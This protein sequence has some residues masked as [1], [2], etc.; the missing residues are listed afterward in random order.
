MQILTATEAIS[1]AFA[2]TKL[3]L[4]SPFRAG[5]TWKLSAT[6][7]LSFAGTVF[8]PF[9]LIYAAAGLLI[10]ALPHVFRVLIV[11][12]S[13][14]LTAI[15]ILA[16]WLCGRLKFAFFD[17]V[18]HRGE[19]V[20]P[21]WRKYG[22]QSRQWTL[23][24]ML[25]GSVFTMVLALPAYAV[26]RTFISALPA[27]QA[28]MSAMDKSSGFPPEMANYMAAFYGAYFLIMLIVAAYFIVISTISSFV[29]PTMALEN[30]SVGD[31][32]RRFNTFARREPKQLAAFV[33][34]RIGLAIVGYMGT[35]LAYEIVLF[36][37]MAVAALVCGIIGLLLHL[38]GV[39]S[40]V[41]LVLGGIVLFFFVF[42]VNGY[43][44][45][46]ALGPFFAFF[47]AHTL[48][49]LGGRY[50]LLGELL[51][52]STPAPVLASPQSPPFAQPYYPPPT[53]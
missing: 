29:V 5:R 1:P 42:V 16:F 18:L 17:I 46:L 53:H 2:R 41:L 39:P 22:E 19:F 32:F 49:F 26:F 34:V 51:E 24:K 21:A 28:Q 8:L 33:G 48:Y 7:Y 15:Y 4:Y 36:I 43:L 37:L 40:T 6:A 47:E 52:R 25:L 23:T 13:I 30:A 11:A 50:P 35:T 38:A 45:L 31:A 44:L 12:G 9:T 20:A 14:V 27:L 3:I 10:P